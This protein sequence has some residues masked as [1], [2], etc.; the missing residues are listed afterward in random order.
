MPSAVCC[1]HNKLKKAGQL[2]R[3]QAQGPTSAS[4]VYLKGTSPNCAS[5]TNPRFVWVCYKVCNYHALRETLP[6]IMGQTT[7]KPS[8]STLSCRAKDINVA[9]AQHSGNWQRQLPLLPATRTAWNSVTKAWKNFRTYTG[10]KGKCH[11]EVFAHYTAKQTKKPSKIKEDWKR[12]KCSTRRSPNF[13]ISAA[14]T[15]GDTF[16]KANGNSLA[17]QALQCFVQ[18]FLKLLGHLLPEM[19]QAIFYWALWIGRAEHWGSVAVKPCSSKCWEKKV[20]KIK[21]IHRRTLTVSDSLS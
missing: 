7:N 1:L 10:A 19:S 15:K 8:A 12:K 4:G 11:K 3:H 5:C 18:M 21:Q 9:T 13:S 16:E 6:L 2:L 17:E 14:V 20:H